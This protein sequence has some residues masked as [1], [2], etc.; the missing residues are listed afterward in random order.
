MHIITPYAFHS[1]HHDVDQL[2]YYMIYTFS[3]GKKLK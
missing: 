3:D 2:M 1:L